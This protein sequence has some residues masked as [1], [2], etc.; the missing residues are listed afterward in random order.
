MDMP[1]R[2]EAIVS[3]KVQMVM[4]RDFV[5]RKASRLK[6]TGEV[7]NL[8]DGTVRVV[9]EGSHATLEKLLEKLHKGPLLARVDAVAPS[10]HAPT[11]EYHSFK[12]NYAK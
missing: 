8:Q 7:Q 6:L 11:N 3:G 5:Q 4:F 1:E 2:L 9:A 12:I 10:W